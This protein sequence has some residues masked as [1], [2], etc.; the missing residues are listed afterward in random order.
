MHATSFLFEYNLLKGG[1]G[2]PGLGRRKLRFGRGQRRFGTSWFVESRRR[3]KLAGHGRQSAG[4]LLVGQRFRPRWSEV[5]ESAV[6]RVVLEEQAVEHVKVLHPSRVGGAVADAVQRQAVVKLLAH[7]HD[8]RAVKR[9]RGDVARVSLVVAGS[10][11]G[12]QPALGRPL[13]VGRRKVGQGG[14]QVGERD[15]GRRSFGEVF[16]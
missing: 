6:H 11:R 5:G 1:R 16:G 4:H 7:G 3:W 10:L 13:H 8:G 14:G 12:G 15:R 9:H 2:R